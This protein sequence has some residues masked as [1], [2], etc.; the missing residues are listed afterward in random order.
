MVAPGGSCAEVAVRGLNDQVRGRQQTF[1]DVLA[2]ALETRGTAVVHVHADS[3]DGRHVGA[4][5]AVDHLAAVGIAQGPERVHAEV[6]VAAVPALEQRAVGFL[7]RRGRVVERAEVPQDAAAGPVLGDDLLERAVVVMH[8]G[9]AAAAPHLPGE[10]D[11]VPGP[12]ERLDQAQRLGLEAVLL[13]RVQQTRRQRTGGRRRD[14]HVVPR[15]ADANAGAAHDDARRGT[16]NTRPSR[17]GTTG[18]R[19]SAG[20]RR[21]E[22]NPDREAAADRMT[23]GR[24]DC[25][26]ENRQ[27]ANRDNRTGPSASRGEAASSVRREEAAGPG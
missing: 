1:D 21:A 3:A 13:G 14:S 6:D 9:D 4:A 8:A 20:G 23:A 10:A 12:E 17:D 18:S 19:H 5:A 25:R 11:D 24:P 27:P 26:P 7:H 2:Q 22:R 16:T 15:L